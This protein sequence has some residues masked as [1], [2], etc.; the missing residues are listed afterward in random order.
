MI[1]DKKNLRA[2]LVIKVTQ[3]K[4]KRKIVYL[5]ILRLFED[6]QEMLT[7]DLNSK[8]HDG[9]E[10]EIIDYYFVEKENVILIASMKETRKLK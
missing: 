8:F 1:G 10:Y 5:K 3:N 4:P 2:G 6:K 9:R 7:V